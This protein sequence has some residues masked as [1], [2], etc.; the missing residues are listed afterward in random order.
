MIIA[1]A[2][3]PNYF[4]VKSVEEEFATTEMYEYNP[5]NTIRVIIK[6][7]HLIIKK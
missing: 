4:A 7:I 5:R 6:I 2:F 1:G 3:Y